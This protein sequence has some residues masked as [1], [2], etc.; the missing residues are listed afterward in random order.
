MVSQPF[1]LTGHE[2]IHTV[3]LL[4]RFKHH[5]YDPNNDEDILSK[6]C[7][8]LAGLGKCTAASRLGLGIPKVE[9][10]VAENGTVSTS[11]RVL[12]FTQ[13]TSGSMAIHKVI[14]SG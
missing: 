3:F 6:S 10:T 11:T 1:Q 13:G 12:D 14:W 9:S 8:S 7:L 2:A 5:A 4:S